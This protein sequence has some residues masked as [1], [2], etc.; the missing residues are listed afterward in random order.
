M[1]SSEP[2]DVELMV[3][4]REKFIIKSHHSTSFMLSYWKA[5]CTLAELQE[6]KVEFATNVN[7]SL[8]CFK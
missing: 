6:V 1:Y 4:A 5:K 8:T 3:D 2:D 7:S